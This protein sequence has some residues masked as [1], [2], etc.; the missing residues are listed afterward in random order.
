[1]IPKWTVAVAK[2]SNRRLKE[3]AF[4][5]TAA[6]RNAGCWKFF[7]DEGIGTEIVSLIEDSPGSLFRFCDD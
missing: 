5:G 1:L 4:R 2:P 3:V 7:T 6:C